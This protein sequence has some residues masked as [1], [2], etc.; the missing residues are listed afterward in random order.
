MRNPSRTILL[1]V[2]M[3]SLI[4]PPSL[5]AGAAMVDPAARGTA[6]TVLLVGD[7]LSIDLGEQ[8]ETVFAGRP[9]VRFAHLGKVSSGLANPAFFNWDAQLADQV[10]KHHPD[11]VLIMVGANDNK[12]LPTLSGRHAAFGTKD[13]ADAYAARVTRLYSIIRADNPHAK[14]YYL[15]VPVM[16][17]PSFDAQTVRINTVLAS[18]ARSLPDASFVETRDVLADGN[19]A[20]AA[21]GRTASGS[22]VRLRAKDGVHISAIGSQLLAARCLEAISGVVGLSQAE[23]VASLD[24]RAVLPVANA[25][26]ASEP[27]AVAEAKPSVT[28]KIQTV[29]PAPVAAV[30]PAAPV[31]ATSETPVTAKTVAVA[32]AKPA[33]PTVA[34]VKPATSTVVAMAK[35]ALAPET[36]PATERPA[37]VAAGAYTVADGDTLWS[38]ARRMGISADQL[39]EANPGIDARHLSLGQTLAVPDGAAQQVAER[40]PVAAAKPQAAA[41]K[42]TG[43][44]YTVADG[45]NLWSV[46]RQFDVTVAAVTQANPGVDPARLRIGQTL[47]IPGEGQEAAAKPAANPANPAAYTV[48]DGDNLWSI[49]HRLGVDVAELKRVNTGLDPLR[50]H[51]GQVLTLPGNVRADVA[52]KDAHPS[53][54][55]SDA[56]LYPVSKGDTMWSLARR[57]GVS[58]DAMLSLNGEIDPGKLQVGQLVTIPGGGHPVATSASLVFPVS[59]GDTL[60]GIARRFDLTVEALVAANPG[61][62]PLRLREGQ[63]LHVPSSLAAVATPEPQPAQAPSAPVVS[64][65]ATQQLHSVVSGDTLWNLARHYGV[66]LDR[67]LKENVGV[68]PDHLQVGQ[69]V[70]LPA[71]MVS[72]AAR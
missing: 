38:V 4:L 17:D 32:P 55:V 54:T 42:K 50:L 2:L 20:F 43:L 37:P 35:P 52:K 49:A 19:G 39:A 15:G 34:A 45:D 18:T 33:T 48:A 14:V 6:Q 31:A 29:A 72:M 57:F 11:V 59:A 44:S 56:G 68:D 16:A 67:L 58:L 40:T 27:V 65:G 60:W 62:D 13:W 70:R 30:K 22:L 10:K 61:V 7:S 3:A 51:P 5:P 63:K 66:S 53:R 9:G 46:A 24:S 69:L 36:H 8:L 21:Q 26:A 71:S 23:L 47:A 41:P 64:N 1:A 28:P 25:G 12:N